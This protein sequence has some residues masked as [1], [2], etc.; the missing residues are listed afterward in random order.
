MS[1]STRPPANSLKRPGA[2]RE[3][4][5]QLVVSSDFY[6]GYASAGRKARGL[7]NL[8]CWAHVR[9]HFVRAGDANPD[10]LSETR[11]PWPSTRTTR[12]SAT[13]SKWETGRSLTSLSLVS[14]AGR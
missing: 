5:R 9:R 12:V 7:V 2:D 11:M 4:P 8:Y 3:G 13:V 6:S 1:G 10:Q 14:S